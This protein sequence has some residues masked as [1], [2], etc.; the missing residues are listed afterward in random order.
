MVFQTNVGLV[1]LGK[2]AAGRI[3][4]RHTLLSQA[5]PGSATPSENTVH[6]IPLEPSTEPPPELEF[7]DPPDDEEDD[8]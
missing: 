5:G 3:S 6:V 7:R 1:A 2:D 4:L 8:A